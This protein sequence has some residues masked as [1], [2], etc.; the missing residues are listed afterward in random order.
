MATTERV[1]SVVHGHLQLLVQSVLLDHLDPHLLI[2]SHL[3]NEVGGSDLQSIK[4]V[5]VAK[6]TT[7][8][9]EAGHLVD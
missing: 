7:L 6:T 3:L 4:A 2:P 8:R 1:N 5:I 9:G